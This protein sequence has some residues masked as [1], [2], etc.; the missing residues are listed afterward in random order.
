MGRIFA[1]D[2]CCIGDRMGSTHP[3]ESAM[4]GGMSG[5]VDIDIAWGFGW[6]QGT[7]WQTWQLKI[8]QFDGVFFRE[9]HRSKWWVFSRFQ[10]MFDYQMLND[11]HQW[12]GE[13]G[14]FRSTQ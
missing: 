10:A 2:P 7:Q 5:A 12:G 8:L 4:V 13:I 3:D 11:R 1:A 14:D 9:N 6:W